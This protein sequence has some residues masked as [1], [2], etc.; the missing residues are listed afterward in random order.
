MNAT[1]FE[2]WF[3]QMLLNLEEP[4]IIVMDNASYHSSLAENY[5]KSNSRK[6]D[7]QQWL[8]DKNIDFS[9]VETL[10]ELR[11]KVKLSMPR[12][13]KYKLDELTFEM[14]HE[15]VGFPLTTASITQ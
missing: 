4:S 13:K 6:A 12:G 11:E 1:I 9:P 15:V 10:D 3:S 5:P 14:G 8:R 2:S 7:V